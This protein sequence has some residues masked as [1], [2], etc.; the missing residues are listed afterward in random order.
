M[1][2]LSTTSLFVY[3]AQQLATQQ[4]AA[5]F[6]ARRGVLQAVIGVLQTLLSC[7][8][9]YLHRFTAVKCMYQ[10]ALRILQYLVKANELLIKIGFCL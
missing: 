2:R 1:H 6:A 3:G 10:H 8:Q 7:L 4:L 5:G 9:L